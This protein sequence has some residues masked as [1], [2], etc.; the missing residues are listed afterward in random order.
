MIR[1]LT[2]CES[3]LYEV[4]ICIDCHYVVWSFVR[5]N[6]ISRLWQN[7]ETHL[8]NAVTHLRQFIAWLD[9]DYSAWFE[10]AFREA[11]EFAG[12]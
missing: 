3:V 10:A 5:V 11:L 9:Q 4:R 8:S 2:D 1:Q 7:V 6:G 12:A